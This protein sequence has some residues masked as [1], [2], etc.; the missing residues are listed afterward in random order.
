[1]T[2]RIFGAL[3]TVAVVSALAGC[4][5]NPIEAAIDRAVT[6]GLTESVEQQIEAETGA[7]VDLGL[8]GSLPDSWPT[9]IPV[10]SGEITS[11]LAADGDFYLGVTVADEG[12][13]RAGLESLKSAGFEQTLEQNADGFFLYGLSDGTHDVTYSWADDGAGGIAVSIIVGS[14]AQ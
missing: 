6:E 10:P 7:E 14:T 2:R 1:V 3:T 8:G 9:N 5:Q 11:S 12:A 4:F 13:A